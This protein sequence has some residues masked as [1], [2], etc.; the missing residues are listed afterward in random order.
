MPLRSCPALRRTAAVSFSNRYTSK[1][2]DTAVMFLVRV[3]K[4]KS[5]ENTPPHQPPSVFPPPITPQPTGTVG[6]PASR[7]AVDPSRASSEPALRLQ[8]LQYDSFYPVQH[9]NLRYS[10]SSAAPKFTRLLQKRAHN[11]TCTGDQQ[12]TAGIPARRFHSRHY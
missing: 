4:S 3:N 5:A 8:L 1:T 9:L 10:K 7:S 12:R 11:R 6:L 2:S